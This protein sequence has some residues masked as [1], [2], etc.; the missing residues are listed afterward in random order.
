MDLMLSVVSAELA[1][2]GSCQ[3]PPPA[4]L[5]PTLALAPTSLMRLIWQIFQ[6]VSRSEFFPPGQHSSFWPGVKG[7]FSMYCLYTMFISTG[8]AAGNSLNYRFYS[9]QA[10]ADCTLD[11]TRGSNHTTQQ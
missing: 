6:T 8:A 9:R 1:D 7:E 11:Q 3:P 2:P 4:H 5:L 10:Q